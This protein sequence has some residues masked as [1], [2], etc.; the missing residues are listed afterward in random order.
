MS[1]RVPE[2]RGKSVVFQTIF[3]YIM[4]ENFTFLVK[5]KDLQFGGARQ[6][7]VSVNHQKNP[8]LHIP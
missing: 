1:S 8:S 6:T 7:P 2:E 3:E 4:T 5:D